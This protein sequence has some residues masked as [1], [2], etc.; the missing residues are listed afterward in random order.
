MAEDMGVFMFTIIIANS[1]VKRYK[2]QWKAYNGKRYYVK[3]T[4]ILHSISLQDV[5]RK[6][7]SL[8]GI[9]PDNIIRI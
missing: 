9:Q 1:T 6:A 7:L 2:L 4:R 5:K 8:F 3:K